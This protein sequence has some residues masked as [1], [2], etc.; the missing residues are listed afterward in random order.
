MPPQIKRLILLFSVFIGLFV[1]A[2]HFLI[3]KSFGKYGHYR[4]DSIDDIK[5]LPISYAGVDVC[6]AC[7]EDLYNLKARSRHAKVNCESCH[8]P[9]VKHTEDPMS[10]KPDKPKGRQFCALCHSKNPSRPKNIPQIDVERH[11]A[12][13]DCASCHNPH[14]P[15]LK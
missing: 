9:A 12:G 11:N 1:L 14:S 8:G 5:L 4:A 7:H 13:T 6:K 10:V 3:P 2:R 15:K